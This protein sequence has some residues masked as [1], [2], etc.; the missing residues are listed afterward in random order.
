M[1]E[2]RTRE[3]RSKGRRG[4][5]RW[6]RVPNREKQKQNPEAGQRGREKEDRRGQG[7]SDRAEECGADSGEIGVGRGGTAHT[8]PAPTTAPVEPASHPVASRAAQADGSAAPAVATGARRQDGAALS[9]APP[10][11]SQPRSPRCQGPEGEAGTGTRSRGAG[12][13]RGSTHS[14]RRAPPLHASASRPRPLYRPRP[15][16]FLRLRP[17]GRPAPFPPLPPQAVFSL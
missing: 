9:L 7:G 11:C 6:A 12:G 3:G 2:R 5:S 1:E 14:P 13:V 16:H 15:R 10:R 8:T 17:Q 4:G